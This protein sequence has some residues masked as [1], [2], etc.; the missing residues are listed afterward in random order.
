MYNDIR[1]VYASLFNLQ[2]QWRREEGAKGGASA[3][4]G[5]VQGTAFG[6]A[7]Y[8]ILKFGRFW[9][10]GVCIAGRIHPQFSVLCTDHTNAIVVT[11]YGR[12]GDKPKRRKSKRRQS[13]TATG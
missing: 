8:G 5:T 3:P 13:K 4:G 9:R 6:G 11:E 2:D 7:K 12:N 1:A 10:I